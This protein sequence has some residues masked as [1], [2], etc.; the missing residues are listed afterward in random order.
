MVMDILIS[1]LVWIICLPLAGILFP[2]SLFIW[3]ITFPFD[4]ER[5][6]MHWWLVWQS[7]LFAHAVPLWKVKVEGREKAR[8]GTS[9]I[10][11]SNHQ[12]MI[13]VLIMNCLRYRFRWIS[14]IENF[15]VPVIGWY[16]RMAKYITVDRGNKESKA[17]MM[18]RSAESL[19]K[20][21]SIMIFPEG[22]R[23]TSGE[24]GPFKLGAFQLA[25]M[26]D[27]PILPVV[28]DGTREVLPKHGMIF[29]RG[30]IIRLKVLDP[31]FPGSFGT[32]DP[33]ELSL[34]FR[35]MLADELEKMRNGI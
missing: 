32:S 3:F 9:Y 13:D 16:L 1:T 12:S 35:S 6:I 21:I 4:N 30:H 11:I 31:V 25:M 26:T 14:K 2:V 33:E 28:L 24:I 18:E 19:K 10:I 20:G 23:S 8:K 27:K 29:S 17:E 5:R 22:T 34:R 15:R 7:N